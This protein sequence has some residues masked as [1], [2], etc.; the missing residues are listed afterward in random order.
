MRIPR[1]AVAVGSLVVATAL[2]LTGCSP[3]GA[4]DADIISVNGTEPLNPLIPANTVEAGGY[5]I[6][7]ALFSGLV[8]YDASGAAVD[9]LAESIAPN[10]D[11]TVYTVSIEDGTTFTDGEEVTAESF[12]NAWDWAALAR[13]ATLKRHYFSDIVG[14]S[15]DTD[16]S[17][18]EAGGLVVVDEHTFEIHLKTSLSDYPH[19]LGDIAFAPLPSAFF[20]NP[21]AFGKHPIGNG[22]Y[23]FDGADA[24]QHGKRLE[25]VVNP[26]YSG[27]RAPA[28]DGL[29]MRFYDSLDIAYADLLSGNLDVLDRLPDRALATFKSELGTRWVDQ[30]LATLETITI[31][32]GLAHF[33]GP[34][35]ELRRDAL[36]QAIDRRSIVADIF[37][38]TRVAARDFTSPAL[39]GY[40]S[41]LLG[42]DVLSFS[43]NSAVANWEAADEISPWEGPFEIAYNA[44]GGHQVWVQA[45]AD[46]IHTVLGIDVVGV[47][48]PSLAD[49]GDAIEDGS[50]ASAYRTGVRADFPGVQGFIGPYYATQG[51]ANTSGYG[52]PDFDAQLVL[53][54]TAKSPA[55]AAAAYQDAQ[56]LL[57]A[58]LP[59]LPLWNAVA[60]AGYGDGIAG[61]ALDWRAVPLY[62]LITKRDG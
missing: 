54:G 12:V 28:N 11:N 24:W 53:A 23:M 55:D 29:T 60:Q 30:P 34:E 46:S 59:A 18:I 57:L 2:L 21:A 17:L 4:D 7:D 26:G 32:Q 51:S 35:G 43:K 14:Y 10:A 13:N 22:P 5:R 62:H 58:D 47:P 25:L 42:S 8:Y 41:T 45:V 27:K 1:F 15:A 33:S 19:R 9:E 6:L 3:E 16:S 38:N 40:S 49:L 39:D 20:V 56:V 50:I 31:P 61:V 44:D 37:A 48:Y 52:N 36:S